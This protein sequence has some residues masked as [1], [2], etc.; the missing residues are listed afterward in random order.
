MIFPKLC[1]TK[2]IL[3]IRNKKRAATKQLFSIESFSVA[4]IELFNISDCKV[5]NT[6]SDYC[7]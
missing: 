7:K 2:L 1:Q 6:N 4:Q 5:G 3:I